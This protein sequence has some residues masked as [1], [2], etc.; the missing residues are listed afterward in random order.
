V[1]AT[2]PT[3]ASSLFVT[4]L[5]EYRDLASVR[6]QLPGADGEVAIRGRAGTGISLDRAQ[7]A[8]GLCPQACVAL[9]KRR[10]PENREVGQVLRLT[11]P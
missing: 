1:S 9:L 4:P 7:Q 11:A 3:D 8:A 6:G 2:Q 5:R 10:L